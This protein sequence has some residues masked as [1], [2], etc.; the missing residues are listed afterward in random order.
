V[1]DL[2]NSQSTTPV[3]VSNETSGNTLAV[4]ADGS[5]N[6][7]GSFSSSQPAVNVLTNQ[8]IT[9]TGSSAAITTNF[10]T[11][12]EITMVVTVQNTPTGTTPSITF[13]L[14]DLDQ[15]GNVFNSTASG[16]ITTAVTPQIFRHT[17][18]SNRMQLNW[19]VTGITPSFTGVYVTLVGSDN[20]ATQPVSGTFFQATQ[21]IS[22]VTLPLPTGAATAANQATEIASLS[23]IDAGIPAALG[24]TTM[25]ASM[26][27]VLAS[28]QTAIPVNATS[29]P[30]V[31]LGKSFSVSFEINVATAAE[32]NMCL[33]RNPA[34]SGKLLSI[35]ES[36]FA[37]TNTVASQSIVRWYINP[38]V[39][40]T[41]AAQTIA[42]NYVKT[43]PT[44]SVMQIFSGPTTSVLGTKIFANSTTGGTAA[45]PF[46]HQWNGL[47]LLDPGRDV[48][49]TG[50]PDGTNR[51]HTITV[52]WSEI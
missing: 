6:V 38:T 34:G 22:V 33:I 25:A 4:N 26:P 35:V 28:N 20:L 45:V 14:F 43:S 37:L 19:T 48:L 8:T 21:P 44:A 27:V 32:T 47:L 29:T 15:V 5:V 31:Q 1:A 3:E 16:A 7:V 2:T 18:Q 10:L 11:S 13:T 50:R 40:A 23:S 39:T 24:Q 46:I 52:F 51:V 49:I 41:G 9:A 42:N 17:L 12:K 36:A 30:D